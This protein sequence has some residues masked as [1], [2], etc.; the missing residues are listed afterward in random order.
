ME[1]QGWLR[2]EWGVTEKNREARFYAL[3]ALGRKQLALETSE[4]GRGSPK[5][6]GA[7]CGTPE[8][9]GPMRWLRR[10][11]NALVSG[12]VERDIRREVSFHIAERTDEL[13]AAGSREAEA[14]AGAGALRQSRP[15]RRSARATP[16]SRA[17]STPCL[18]DLRY[19]AGALARTPAFTLTVVLTLALAIGANTAVFSALD[20]VLLRP[21]PF[22][23]PD[24]LV[25]VSQTQER[26]SGTFIAPARLQ[27]WVRLNRV[28]GARRLLRGGCLRNV[29]RSAGAGP[30]RLR[31]AAVLRGLGRRARAGARLRAR[32]VPLRRPGRRRDQRSLLAPAARRRSRRADA[33]VRLGTASIPIVGVM[34]ATF[35]FPDRTWTS[36]CPCR[37]MRPTRSRGQATWYTGIGRL[38]PGVT[39]A[40]AREN[41][42]AVQAQLAE[43]HPET[44]RGLGAGVVPLD[45]STVGDAGA[46]LWLL[47]GAVTVLL[48]IACTNIA[49]LLL[50]RATARR[51]EIAVRFSLG[52]SRAAVA[53]QMLTEAAVLAAAGAAAGL[54]LA[55]AAAGALRAAAADLPRIEDMAIDGRVLLYTLVCTTSVALLCG[56]LPAIRTSGLMG[57]RDDGRVQ[58]S[59]RSPLQWV[60]VG[61][62]VALAVTLLA[63]AGLLLRSVH[64]L[65]RSIAASTPNAC[66][67]SA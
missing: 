20:T 50:S 53:A 34:P 52:A 12:R 66:S 7:C 46:S 41:L 38:R 8:R 30:A 11:V 17:G 49:A 59:S 58:V 23:E 14:P 27:D 9:G 18:R 6:S 51:H 57:R 16:T 4:A 40:Q 13:R 47:F 48:L 25:Q 21:L 22:P 64:E 24:R 19:A 3:T 67:R 32:R 28:P 55:Y 62:Q 33:A 10:I 26:S 35:R 1:Q 63:G 45:R 36:G 65:S 39:P 60:L 42:T 31:H 54:L 56:L 44:D 61:A 5:A 29:G 15:C 37:W 2:S 43:Q